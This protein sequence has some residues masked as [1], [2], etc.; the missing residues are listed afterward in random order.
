[1]DTL[2][3]NKQIEEIVLE[4]NMLKSEISRMNKRI[5]NIEEKIQT[6]KVDK[7]EDMAHPKYNPPLCMNRQ[8]DYWDWIKECEE[9]D[10]MISS[11]SS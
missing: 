3:C 1:M 5:L 8:K 7:K 10:V 11:L 4:I 9:Y 2:L 6:N